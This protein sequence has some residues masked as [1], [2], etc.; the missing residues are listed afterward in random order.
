MSA[1]MGLNNLQVTDWIFARA[2]KN[3]PKKA[4]AMS[5]K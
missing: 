2:E 5:R 4:A 1:V 3:V